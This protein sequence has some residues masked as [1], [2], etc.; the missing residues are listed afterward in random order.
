MSEKSS[1]IFASYQIESSVVNGIADKVFELIRN[2]AFDRLSPSQVSSVNFVHG[3]PGL[4]GSIVEVRRPNNQKV[5]WHIV[6]I[7]DYNRSMMYELIEADPP[8]QSSNA[9]NT[10]RVFKDTMCSN[11]CFLRWETNYSNDVQ[12]DELARMKSL[13]CEVVR[14]LNGMF[15]QAEARGT[16]IPA[17][18]ASGGILE[19][20]QRENIST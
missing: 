4:V 20:S 15:G 14:T 2:F 12:M 1:D 9:L 17:S 19:G 16:E 7:S 13:K 6:E 5:K 8:F 10:I 3:Q 11:K 18:K